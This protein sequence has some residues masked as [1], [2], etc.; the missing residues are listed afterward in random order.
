MISIGQSIFELKSGNGNVDRQTNGQTNGQNYTNIERN[1]AMMVI[2]LPVRFEFDW[3][4]YFRVRVRKW[5]CWRTNG[6]KNRQTNGRNYTNLKQFWK[7]PSYDGDLSPCQVWIRLDKAFSSYSPEKKC[8]R[9]NKWT[10]KW[11]NERTE[12]HQ[13][14]K[15]P[16]Y[17]GDLSPCQVWIWWDKVFSS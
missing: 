15:E 7:E 5:K 1:L 14:W 10:K 12:L 13:F 8:W 16:T 4:K 3:T 11:T 17:D 6:Q 9:T 2:Y